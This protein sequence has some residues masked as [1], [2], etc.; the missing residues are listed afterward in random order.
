MWPIDSINYRLYNAKKKQNYLKYLIDHTTLID[1]SPHI[2]VYEIA[3]CL[4]TRQV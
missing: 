4:V 2:Y 3:K 1:L